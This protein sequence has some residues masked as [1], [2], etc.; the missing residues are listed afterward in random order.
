MGKGEQVDLREQTQVLQ[1]LGPLQAGCWARASPAGTLTRAGLPLD[2]NRS[3][4]FTRQRVPSVMDFNLLLTGVWTRLPCRTTPLAHQPPVQLLHPCTATPGRFTLSLLRQLFC[5]HPG[6]SDS[7]HQGGGLMA[8]SHSSFPAR[9]T[10]LP[11][12]LPWVS[13][14][15]HSH[16]PQVPGVVPCLPWRAPSAL[17]CGTAPHLNAPRTPG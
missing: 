6:C 4:L 7:A 1:A 10:P 3:F 16:S 14:S 13:A 15:S 11:Q 8:A 9:H 5:P 17:H 2:F 12:S